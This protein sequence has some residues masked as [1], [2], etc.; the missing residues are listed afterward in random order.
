M[1]FNLKFLGSLKLAIEYLNRLGQQGLMVKIVIFRPIR[2]LKQNAYLHLCINY[3]GARLGYTTDEAKTLI[4]RELGYYYVKNG[5]KFIKK[6][7]M[8]NIDEM[9]KFIREFK[10]YCVEKAGFSLPD[11]ELY[12]KDLKYQVEI[13]NEIESNRR[14]LD[15]NY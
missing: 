5:H 6:T 13:N 1:I 15:G 2:T 8:M 12:A 9:S 10:D 14:Y 3:F 7:S 4:K 11:A